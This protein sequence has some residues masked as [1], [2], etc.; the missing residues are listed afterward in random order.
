MIFFRV[1]QTF[2]FFVIMFEEALEWFKFED[3]SMTEPTPKQ[4]EFIERVENYYCNRLTVLVDEKRIDDSAALFEEFVVDGENPDG[5]FFMG[6]F[7]K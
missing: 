4:L 6:D 2:S 5:W 3:E 7:T 1:L